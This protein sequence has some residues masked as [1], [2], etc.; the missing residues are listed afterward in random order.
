D[1]SLALLYRSGPAILNEKPI[2]FGG[3]DKAYN[4]NGIEYGTGVGVEPLNFI[5]SYDPISMSF[6][7]DSLSVS[8]MDMRGI[9]QIDSN[10]Y[11]I[12]GGMGPGQ[13]VSNKTYLLEY[14]IPPGVHEPSKEDHLV[15][16]PNPV[17]GFLEI[18]LPENALV[19]QWMV[20]DVAGRIVGAGKHISNGVLPVSHLSNGLYTVEIDTS[21]GILSSPFLVVK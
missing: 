3:A 14:T 20:R 13:V 8:I 2:W 4:F 11:I 19:Q 7:T 9:A 5:T 6:S 17:S 21:E 1:D 15:V 12:A 10:R 18:R 16:F